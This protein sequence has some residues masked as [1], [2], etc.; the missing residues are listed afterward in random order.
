[1]PEP[2]LA[3]GVALLTGLVIALGI[4]PVLRRLPEPS[5]DQPGADT[6]LRYAQLPT[7]RFVTAVTLLSVAATLVAWAVLPARLQPLWTVLATVGVLLAAI[8]ARTTW[9][10]RTLSVVGWLTMMVAVGG[11]VALGVSPADVGRTATGAA[12]AWGLYL[13]IWAATR[14]GFGFGDVR[15]A[16]LL[17][18]AAAAHS[19][20]LLA[21]TLM[22][23]TVLGAVHGLFRLV[24][25]RNSEFPYAPSMLAGA[26]LAAVI[27]RL[28]G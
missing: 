6:K 21:A 11:S 13:L 9:L 1:M 12:L 19:W 28:S 14:G 24:R 4:A 16:P 7:R 3:L 18:A 23:G 26:Y 17:G 8:D 15:F 20:T 2:A 25:R 10:P 22:L 27:N 5:A